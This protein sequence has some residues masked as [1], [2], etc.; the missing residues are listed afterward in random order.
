MT[1]SI[2]KYGLL[3]TILVL[4]QVFVFNNVL[5]SGYINPLIY[6]FFIFVYP[7]NKERF[8]ILIISFF[9]G[10]SI[11]F[12]SNSGGINAAATLFIAYIRLPVLHTILNKVEFDYLLFDIKKLY[13]LQGVLYVFSLSLIHQIIVYTL[14]YYKTN[15]LISLLFTNALISS[16]LTSLIIG[17]GIS[18]F[19]K[20]TLK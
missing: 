7:L 17:I 12:F 5:F 10:L 13:I 18:L 1:N 3:F 6:I 16:I 11:D 9:L 8:P 14:S 2:F 19:F 4:L 15:G 20:S